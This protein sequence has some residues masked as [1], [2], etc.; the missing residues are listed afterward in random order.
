MRR[1][2]ETRCIHL[3]PSNETKCRHALRSNLSV[4]QREL[5]ANAGRGAEFHWHG[6]G[7]LKVEKADG[8]SGRRERS[9]RARGR[10]TRRGRPEPARRAKR[11]RWRAAPCPHRPR[12]RMPGPAPPRTT[13]PKLRCL[14]RSI[15][16]RRITPAC[17]A[18]IIWKMPRSMTSPPNARLEKARPS[19]PLTNAA[20][21]ESATAAP[22][23]L[24]S[25]CWRESMEAASRRASRTYTHRGGPTDDPGTRSGMMRMLNGS[26]TPARTRL[27]AW[28]TARA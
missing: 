14:S 5:P 18:A 10:R 1:T 9:A 16:S 2:S 20:A 7:R 27:T 17:S 19:N 11:T 25:G 28:C 22:T 23:A 15:S 4:V 3:L 21:T 13:T 24:S 12:C 8:L 6:N 26:M